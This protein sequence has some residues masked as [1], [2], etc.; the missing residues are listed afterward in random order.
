M[1]APS[2]N[3]WSAQESNWGLVF[4]GLSKM[5]GE[6]GLH[7]LRTLHPSRGTKSGYFSDLKMLAQAAASASG[8]CSGVYITLNPVRE[9]LLARAVNR[10]ISAKNTTSD[11]DILRRNRLPIDFDAVRPA[12]ISSTEVERTLALE[13]ARQCRDW[14]R[15][16]S[17]PN[18]VL[19]DSGNGGHLVYWIDLPNDITS[20]DLVKRCLEA[21]ALRF[22]DDRVVVDLT[23]YNAARIWKIYGTLA[24][25]GDSTPDRPHR[26]AAIIETPEKI[27]VVP[28][29]LMERL[30]ATLPPAGTNR[31]RKASFDLRRWITEHGLPVASESDWIG[32]HRY[33]LNPCPWNPEHTNKSAFV[34]QLRTGAIAAGCLHNGCAAQDWR[35]LRE[36]YEP[37]KSG[38]RPFIQQNAT[39][40]PAIIVSDRPMRDMS[41]E[42]LRAL[43]QSNHPPT[44]SVVSNGDWPEPQSLGSE[45]LPV[46]PL[47]LDFLPPSLRP[48]IDDISERMQAP[49]DFSAAVAVVSLAGCC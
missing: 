7:E 31:S 39:S 11:A 22:S 19:A 24:A 34:V 37:T 43:G 48:M 12:G 3:G 27:E 10:L 16:Q 1:T 18:P 13:R 6:A 49:P 23:T 30:V 40:L 8:N 38:F 25:K 14:L 17:W 4:A 21:L 26:L 5:F 36:K 9:E 33:I 47:S 42:S 29:V 2:Q 41:D 44:I 28:T 15:L 46:A 35:T 32:G 20:T 45:L